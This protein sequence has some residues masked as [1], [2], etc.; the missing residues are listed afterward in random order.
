[1]VIKEGRELWPGRT[2]RQGRGKTSLE[3]WLQTRTEG[4]GGQQKPGQPG[5]VG[6]REE[7]EIEQETE[8][9]KQGG[10]E[11]QVVYKG[12]TVETSHMRK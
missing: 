8:Q 3:R 12:E 7:K 1:M 2:S 9:G 11:A 5:K 10:A 4:Q 6:R